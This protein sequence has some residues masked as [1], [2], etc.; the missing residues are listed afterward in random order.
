VLIELM[1][2]IGLP[3]GIA[4]VGYGA[5]DIDD[6]VEG[7]LKQ[8]RLL[9]TAPRDVEGFDLAGIFHRSLSLW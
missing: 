5:A 1:R 6:L 4:A 8:Q 2:D 7:A 9:A 3:N